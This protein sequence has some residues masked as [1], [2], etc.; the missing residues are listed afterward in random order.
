MLTAHANIFLIG[1]KHQGRK[2]A[3]TELW[4]GKNWKP[5]HPLPAPMAYHCVV[6][7]NATTV[8]FIAD[9]GSIGT[10][11]QV[12]YFYSQATG[13][14]QTEAPKQRNGYACGLHKDYVVIAG[15]SGAVDVAYVT[16]EFFSLDTLTWHVG[17]SVEHEWKKYFYKG[18]WQEEKKMYNFA[19][20]IFNW[21][22]RTFWIG[23]MTIWELLGE[24][25][26]WQWTTVKEMDTRRGHF[27][28]FLMTA[29]EC[30]GWK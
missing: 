9:I 21:K 27:E 23:E 2:K 16:S 18:K 30:S 17:P 14:V 28:A 24:F 10:P 20:A 22:G 4:D 1:G 8:F 6:K 25:G 7:I 13:F 12:A 3:D 29:Q 15:G 26:S 11:H 19:G 5:H